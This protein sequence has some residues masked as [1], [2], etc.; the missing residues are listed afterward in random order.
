MCNFVSNASRAAPTALPSR[1]GDVAVYGFDINQP[2]LP[3]LF[4][5]PVLVSIPV[6]MALSTVFHSIKSPDNSPLSDSVLL[7]LLDLSTISLLMK[8]S[9]SPDIIL[10]G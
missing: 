8:I 4:F 2:S 9:L 1:C 7:V 5:Y 6:F 10:C 3:T